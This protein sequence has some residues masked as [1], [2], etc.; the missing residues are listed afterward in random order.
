MSS[1]NNVNLTPIHNKEAMKIIGGLTP[2]N[3][4]KI[5]G[6]GSSSVFGGDMYP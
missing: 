1:K 6:A 5:G 3:L 2:G 4:S